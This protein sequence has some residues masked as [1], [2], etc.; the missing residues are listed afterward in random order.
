MRVVGTAAP[1]VA[2]R[3]KPLRLVA[4]PAGDLLE[5][6]LDCEAEVFAR[7]FGNTRA[8]LETE[9]GP[10][11]DQSVFVAVADQSGRVMAT[12]RLTHPGPA[13]LKTFADVAL[14]PWSLDAWEAVRLAGVDPART[15]DV[16]TVANRATGAERVMAGA[17]MWHGLLQ[18]AAAND[19]HGMVALLD[20]K[21]RD[22]V[23]RMGMMWDAMPGCSSAPYLGSPGTT[24]V[25]THLPSFVEVQRRENPEA[26]RFVT[27]G[28]GLVD[29]E[30]PPLG[31][32][33]VEGLSPETTD[34]REPL[35]LTPVRDRAEERLDRAAA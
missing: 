24:P 21:V 11:A 19:M 9:Y 17:A 1:D 5:G 14:P 29:V 10:Y 32:F 35:A 25:C 20:D 33:V 26:Y 16:T 18:V 28:Q 22:F 6:A 27:L 8:E 30:L 23:T 12:G 7:R 3:T 31:A 2:T 13:G 15:W 34:R 4:Q